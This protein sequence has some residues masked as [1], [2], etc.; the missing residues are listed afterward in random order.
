MSVIDEQGMRF[1]NEA[2]HLLYH[3]FLSEAQTMRDADGMLGLLSLPQ[4]SSILDVGCG[5]GRH[6]LALAKRGYQVT[7]LDQSEALLKI[8]QEQ[9]REQESN[10]QWIRGDMR[11]LPWTNRFRAVINVFSS[12]GL[13]EEEENLFVLQQMHH[14]L[15]PGGLLLLE[16]LQLSRVVRA[17]SPGGVIRG[18]NGLLVVEERTFD[19]RTSRYQVHDIVLFPDGVRREYPHSLRIYTLTELLHAFRATGFEVLGLYGN[20]NG[21]PVTLDSRFVLIGRRMA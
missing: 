4:G 15:E 9:M 11:H 1:F 19:L 14:A 7:G 18:N 3:P 21:D 13:F 8:A 6:A 20:L 5:W 16:V 12:F 10:V 17:F 2:Y